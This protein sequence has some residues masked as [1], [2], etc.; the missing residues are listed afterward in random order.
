MGVAIATDAC[1]ISGSASAALTATAKAMLAAG[2]ASNAICLEAAIARSAWA[3]SSHSKQRRKVQQLLLSAAAQPALPYSNS[4]S[5]SL[6]GLQQHQKPCRWQWCSS[7][8][9]SD[10]HFL[11][12]ARHLSCDVARQCACSAEHQPLAAITLKSC[13]LRDYFPGWAETANGQAAAT[14]VFRLS[15]WS[16]LINTCSSL[17]MWCSH[18][19]DELL[20]NVHLSL[21]LLTCLN[22]WRQM[23]GRW[24]S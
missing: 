13:S 7:I 11:S 22:T 21:H 3:S 15:V 6:P 2:E 16:K 17:H 19:L 8:R 23:L 1:S 4:N 20:V 14:A 9:Q 5:S 12:A 24:Q 18:R 10:C